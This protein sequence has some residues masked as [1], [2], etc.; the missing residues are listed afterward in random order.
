MGIRKYRTRPGGP[1]LHTGG[2]H[3]TASGRVGIVRRTIGQLSSRQPFSWLCA[4]VLHRLDLLVYR[5]TRR[6]STFSTWAS[7]LPLVMLT[8]VGARTG[9]RRTVPVLGIPDGERLI[10]IA[11]NFGQRRNPAWYYNL[12]ADPCA[13]VTVDGVTRQ[14]EATELTGSERERCFQLGVRINPGWLRY[15]ARAAHRE[16]PVIMLRTTTH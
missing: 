6:R 7:G 1:M 9:A 3:M 4:R 2:G 13:M 12:K 16:I 5:N 10:V 8:T 11:S 15:R 14:V